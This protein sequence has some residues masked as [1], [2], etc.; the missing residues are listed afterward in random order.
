MAL[1]IIVRAMWLVSMV[2]AEPLPQPPAPGGFCK[3]AR[4]CVPCQRA[5]CSVPVTG[6]EGSSLSQR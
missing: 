4:A 5:V 1:L 3:A 2:G 6:A